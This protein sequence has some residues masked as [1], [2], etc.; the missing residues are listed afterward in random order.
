MIDDFNRSLQLKVKRL[1]EREQSF[2]ES[3]D[4]SVEPD[5]EDEGKEQRSENDENNG[6]RETSEDVAGGKDVSCKE[7][8]RENRSFNESNSTENRGT[9]EKL[10]PDSVE[11]GPIK[12]DPEAKPVW[13]EDS[14]NDS[15]DRHKASKRKTDGDS[16]A[17]LRDSVSESKEGTKESSDVQSSASLTERRRKRVDAGGGRV[18]AAASPAISTKRGS[19]VKPEALVGL[20]DIIR[21]HK[22]GQV[23]QRRLDTQVTIPCFLVQTSKK[24]CNH[25]NSSVSP[26]V[27]I[28]LDRLLKSPSVIFI[29]TPPLTLYSGHLTCS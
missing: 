22:H 29:L 23:F 26:D 14:C 17:E 15:S 4:V 25:F 21:S 1:E 24:K 6:G 20:L 5:L 19:A 16:A 8:D 9:G 3:K 13:E 27:T 7:S 2:R 28:D 11:A 18:T 10:G 12:P